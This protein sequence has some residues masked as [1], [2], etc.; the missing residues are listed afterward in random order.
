MVGSLCSAEAFQR[1]PQV[2][3]QTGTMAEG[4]L[5]KTLRGTP[6]H[7][8]LEYAAFIGVDGWY[9]SM[10]KCEEKESRF[11]RETHSL[12]GIDSML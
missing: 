2:A 8:R 11:E 7:M 4:R 3:R 1:D 5:A 6:Q 12:E 10:R 9:Q